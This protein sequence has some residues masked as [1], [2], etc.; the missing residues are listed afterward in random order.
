MSGRDWRLFGRM[1]A[2]LYRAFGGRFVSKVGLG[3]TVLLLTTTGR[4]SGLQRTTP[5]IYMPAGDD[6]I[7]YAS[8]GGKE[9]P[10]AW[11]LNLQANPDAA[12]Q[13]GRKAERVLARR[14]TESEYAELWPKAST[15]NPHWRDYERDTKR[16]IPLVILERVD[17]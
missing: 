13:I 11:W 14:A 16:E 10:P 8:N 5:L 15:Y 2:K 3:R 4:K 9:T 1:H 12:V 17:V 7:V 6:L